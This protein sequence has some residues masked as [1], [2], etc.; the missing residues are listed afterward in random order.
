MPRLAEFQAAHPEI[1]LQI[2]TRDQN[3]DFDPTQCDAVI[4]FGDEGLP[5][6]E[7]RLILRETMVAVCHPDL[8]PGRRPLDLGAL[9]QQKLLHLSSA[10]HGE[11]WMRFFKG[12][13]HAIPKPAPHDRFL[14][15]MVYL[16]AIQNGLGIGIGLDRILA[17]FLANGSLVLAC[18]TR[19]ET[20]RGYHGSLTPTGARKEGTAEFLEWIGQLA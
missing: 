5:G 20:T 16:R 11:D 4:R 12:T 2:L 19:C 7:S 10:D 1:K 18:E 3:A 8:L 17:E 13:D 6:A 9:A 14:S 15:Y